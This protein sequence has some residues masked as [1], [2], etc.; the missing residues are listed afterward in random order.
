MP[1]STTISTAVPVTTLS[2]NVTN[3]SPVPSSVSIS[4][5]T[6]TSTTSN[7][8]NHVVRGRKLTHL[9][10]TPAKRKARLKDVSIYFFGLKH[11]DEMFLTVSLNC[12]RLAAKSCFCFEIRNFPL[13]KQL[14]FGGG[15]QTTNHWKEN[16]TFLDEF[17]VS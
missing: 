12:T 11:Y 13:E 8:I 6:T 7:N 17:I 9:H 1:K 3:T 5:N 4:T 15:G 16:F 14:T 10:E 2:N